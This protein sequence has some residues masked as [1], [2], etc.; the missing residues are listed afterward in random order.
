MH[1]DSFF[2]VAIEEKKM[3]TEKKSKIV[4]ELEADDG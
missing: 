3:P 4:T 1:Q 2:I